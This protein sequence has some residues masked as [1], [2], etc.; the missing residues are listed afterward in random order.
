MQ[1]VLHADLL[2]HVL[3]TDFKTIPIISNYIA[4]G[5]GEGQ[6]H[7]AKTAIPNIMKFLGAQQAKFVNVDNNTKDIY[8][9][10]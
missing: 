2:Q 1:H 5:F 10:P 3:H 4:K 9:S 8:N 6:L 7:Q